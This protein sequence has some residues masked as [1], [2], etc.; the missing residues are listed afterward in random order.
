VSASNTIFLPE[1]SLLEL[2]DCSKFS[3]G[4]YFPDQQFSQLEKVSG[5]FFDFV[6]SKAEL[7]GLHT[8]EYFKEKT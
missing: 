5:K 2:L 1:L 3:K 7:R 4:S 8:S 6:R